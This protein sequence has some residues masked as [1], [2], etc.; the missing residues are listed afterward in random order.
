M[1][2]KDNHSNQLNTNNDVYWQSRGYAERPDNWE[3]LID[4]E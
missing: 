3:E 1:K 4:K 2:E